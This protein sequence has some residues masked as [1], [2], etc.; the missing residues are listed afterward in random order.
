VTDQIAAALVEGEVARSLALGRLTV[1]Q[2]QLAGLPIDRERAHEAGRFSLEFLGLIHR[3]QQPAIGI[4]LDVG[5][6]RGLRNQPQGHERRRSAR[7]LECVDALAIGL[8]AGVGADVDDGVLRRNG[9][10][11]LVLSAHVN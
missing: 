8:A 7:H 9:G 3:E 10:V 11:R 2:R 4:D 5:G 6:T 1:D